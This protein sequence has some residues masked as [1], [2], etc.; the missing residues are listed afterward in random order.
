MIGCLLITSFV[1]GRQYH[2]FNLINTN[3]IKSIASGHYPELCAAH[4]RALDSHYVSNPYTDYDKM[5][6][7]YYKLLIKTNDE[8]TITN[9]GNVIV[10]INDGEPINNRISY[11]NRSNGYEIYLPYHEQYEV[12]LAKASEI[13]LEVY[14]T[15]K[16][17]YVP[18]DLGF[19]E[20]TSFVI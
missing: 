5:D 11:I 13:Q 4:V 12:K 20:A 2:L 7:M 1:T 16:E 17:E 10:R 18:I 14:F 6:G 8:I 15:E 9:N 19:N 3:N